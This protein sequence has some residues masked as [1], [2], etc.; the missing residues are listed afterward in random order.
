MTQQDA[1]ETSEKEERDYITGALQKP[2]NSLCT[3]RED[4]E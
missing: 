2:T 4:S 1:I 3:Q